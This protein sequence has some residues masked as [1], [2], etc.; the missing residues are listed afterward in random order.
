MQNQESLQNAYKRYARI[1][2]FTFG[3]IINPGRKKVIEKLACLD[4][5][6]ILEVGVGTGLALPLYPKNVH[7]TGIDL[8]E[9][10]LNLA[11]KRV[12]DN[13]MSNVTLLQMNAE[14]MSFEDNQFDKVVALYVASVVPNP[15]KL[16]S[17]MERVCKPDGELYIVNHFYS[18]NP[19]IAFFENLLNPLLTKI[20]G[21]Q[22]GVKLDELIGRTGIEIIE[23]S[24]VNI[25]GNW[26][27]LK[28]KNTKINFVLDQNENK[29]E[30]TTEAITESIA[31]V[32][33]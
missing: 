11:K 30:S 1:Y 31:P 26:T 6:K 3:L 33:Y 29:N 12:F 5:H 7:I 25:L 17:E 21:F 13:Q 32:N 18:K 28:V 22:P 15:E 14:D 9:D 10:M 19:F 27:F 2:D 4:N 20:F 24:K 8:S 23:Q 16:I